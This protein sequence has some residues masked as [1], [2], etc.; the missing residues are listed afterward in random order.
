MVKLEVKIGGGGVTGGRI[1]GMR[2]YTRDTVRSSK[3]E[4][5]ETPMHQL[6]MDDSVV[7]IEFCSTAHKSPK[8]LKGPYTAKN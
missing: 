6:W 1:G 3:Y 5:T 7:S 4:V 2:W 8:S